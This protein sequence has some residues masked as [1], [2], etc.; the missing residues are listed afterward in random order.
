MDED[1]IEKVENE[2]NDYKNLILTQNKSGNLL[3]KW[4]D[5]PSLF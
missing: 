3:K 4:F 5:D 2:L 1:I